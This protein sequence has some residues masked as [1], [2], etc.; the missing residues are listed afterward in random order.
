MTMLESICAPADLRSLSARELDEL[1]CELRSAIID[2][3]AVNGGHL[4][5]NLGAVELTLAF[6]RGFDSPRDALVW[7][8][9]HQTYAHK[10]LTGRQDGFTRLPCSD[11]LSG[12]PSRKASEHDLVENSHASTSLSYAYGLAGAR[13]AA[14]DDAHVVAH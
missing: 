7:D 13:D 2:G 10:L 4:G 9:G 8:T 1:A 3:V 12:Y 11:G 6:H 14:H 5:S